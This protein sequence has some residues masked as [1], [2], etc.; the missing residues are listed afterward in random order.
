ML[1]VETFN[2]E[3]IKLRAYLAIGWGKYILLLR[4]FTKYIEMFA[5]G[6]NMHESVHKC[7]KLNYIN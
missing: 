6:I 4:K 5:L 1:V 2:R 7:I 3:N